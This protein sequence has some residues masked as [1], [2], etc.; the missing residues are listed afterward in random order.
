MNQRPVIGIITNVELDRNYLF[1]GYPRVTLNQDYPRS[2]A[3]AGG[4]PV[5]IMPSPDLSLLADQLSL[6]DA[7]VL[8][9]GQDV[10]P[11][12]YGADP[13]QECG[14]PNAVRDRFELE[15]LQLARA[16]GMPVLGICRGLQITNTFLGGTLH[17]DISH[18]G[19]TQRHMMD[20]NPALGA[21][22]ISVEP[23]SFLDEAW[24]VT[25]ARVNSFHH[26]VV[27]QVAP[28]LSV[29]ARAADG[30]VEAVE[31]TGE[32]FDLVAV[33]WHPEMMSGADSTEGEQARRLFSWFVDLAA[34]RWES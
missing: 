21:H 34:G 16:A 2:I 8:A 12:L 32:E 22:Q 33:Q 7:L 24:G 11:Q 15:A 27:D 29:A 30:S 14:A 26:Q 4:V 31:Y 23:E 10:D 18:S 19:S 13:R 28:G 17:Q 20:A 5:M 1:P 25:E 3:D 6:V 9:G